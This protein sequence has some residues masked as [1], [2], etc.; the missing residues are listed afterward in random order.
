MPLSTGRTAIRHPTTRI[1]GS[2]EPLIG[3]RG[4]SLTGESS[5]VQVVELTVAGVAETG[6]GVLN[7]AGRGLRDGEGRSDQ[8]ILQGEFFGG[9]PAFKYRIF[10]IIHY[11]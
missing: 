11:T 2:R 6:Q 7:L 1:T 5:I 4:T 9:Q 3:N 8:Y 10:V